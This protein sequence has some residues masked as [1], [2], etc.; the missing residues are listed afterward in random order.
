[1]KKKYITLGGS[2]FSLKDLA[3]TFRKAQADVRY[4]KSNK[5]YQVYAS[6]LPL[7]GGV[8]TEEWFKTRKKA[9]KFAKRF[10][11]KYS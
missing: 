6:A 3:G 5:K 2:F 1:M 11:S 10:V 7:I 4:S 9:E 8:S